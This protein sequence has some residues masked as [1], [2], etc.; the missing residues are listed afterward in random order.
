VEGKG[1][2]FIMLLPVT[3][4]QPKAASRVFLP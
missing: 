4:E 1:S 3:P 2:N